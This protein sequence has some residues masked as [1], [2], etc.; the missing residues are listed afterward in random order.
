[1][2]LLVGRGVHVHLDEPHAR[3]VEV[4]L[5]PFGADKSVG[6]GV[7]AH[8]TDLLRSV[9]ATVSFVLAAEC[10]GPAFAVTQQG[11]EDGS[12]PA[13]ASLRSKS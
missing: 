11:A 7:I 6:R 1:M 8:S 10:R 9:M 13:M 4:S 3:I 12:W 2:P 5:R